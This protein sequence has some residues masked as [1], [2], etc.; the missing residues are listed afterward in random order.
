MTKTGQVQEM[1]AG[2]L[3]AVLEW[4]FMLLDKNGKPRV[5]FSYAS[6]SDAEHGKSQMDDA[7]AKVS[8]EGWL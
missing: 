2:V 7:L 4:G 3:A 6:K 5:S 8:N 1:R